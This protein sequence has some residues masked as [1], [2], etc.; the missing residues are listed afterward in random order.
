MPE[1][2]RAARQFSGA[3]DDRAAG[4][5]KNGSRWQRQRRG[6][7]RRRAH[8]ARVRERRR[9]RSRLRAPRVSRF[10]A[11]Q[12]DD[13]IVRGAAVQM[14]AGVVLVSGA[15]RVVRE[16]EV[17]VPAVGGGAQ[18]VRVIREQ[19][20]E[21]RDAE[22][23]LAARDR[24]QQRARDRH[25]A[26]RSGSLGSLCHEGQPPGSSTRCQPRVRFGRRQLP[27]DRADLRMQ[28]LAIP[29]GALARRIARA[30]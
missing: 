22:R 11:R 19:H 26:A 12:V 29:P 6:D 3:K 20:A 23:E 8:R 21:P 30:G 15:R 13:V 17:E 16:H 2:A 4:E 9:Y 25:G 28:R 14:R 1:A 18:R 5:R 7:A 24:L 10:V 27:L